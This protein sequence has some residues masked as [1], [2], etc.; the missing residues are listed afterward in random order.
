MGHEDERDVRLLLQALELQLHAAPELQ[1]ER[2]EGLVEEQHL[3]LLG[4]GAGE[5]AALLL[6]P[7]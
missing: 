4:E 3:R 7:R 1:I 6:S 5:C 2:G